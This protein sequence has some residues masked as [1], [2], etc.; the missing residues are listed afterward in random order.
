MPLDSEHRQIILKTLALVESVSADVETTSYLW[1][2]M[3]L[4]AYRGQLLRT[5]HDLD[6]LTVDLW[7]HFEKLCAAFEREGC[8]AKELVNGDLSVK[9]I[10]TSIHFGHIELT[11]YTR[12]VHNRDSKT[13][14]FCFPN[15]WLS[16]LAYL[17]DGVGTHVVEPEFEYVIKS[18]PTLL[19]PH[20]IPRPKDIDAFEQ[21]K[22][23]LAMRGV[24]LASLSYM[25]SVESPCDTIL[26]K[27][28]RGI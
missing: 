24:D 23:L 12:W 5:H 4:D 21:T 19:N 28:N 7:R 2:G 14:V 26:D 11:E 15:V 8:V 6:Y 16:D 20:W 10:G 18:Q 27:N 17:I 13:G 22:A 1:G 3:A 25:V 9:G